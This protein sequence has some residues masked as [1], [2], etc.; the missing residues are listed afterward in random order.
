MFFL[1]KNGTLLI[2]VKATTKASKNCIRGVENGELLV[3]VTAAPENNK[4]NLAII[5]IVSKKIGVAKSRM[6]IVAGQKCRNKKIAIE[7]NDER[8][9]EILQ[10]KLEEASA[11]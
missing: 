1:H 4:A 11:V 3:N 5:E 9:L 2:S 8:E 6:S 10:K 7:L